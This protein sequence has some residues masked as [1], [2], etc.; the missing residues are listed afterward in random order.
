MESTPT[1]HIYTY[2]YIHVGLCRGIQ[3]TLDFLKSV[4]SNL[5]MVQ[6]DLDDCR[7][8]E[9]TACIDVQGYRI[10]I[11]RARQ[12]K[13]HD[14][15]DIAMTSRRLGVD[16]MVVG[17]PT[18]GPIH[19]IGQGVVILY[20]GSASPGIASDSIS[21][22]MLMDIK[23]NTMA[24]YQYTEQNAEDVRVERFEFSKSM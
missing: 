24:V 2:I 3:G 13:N 11:C 5:T 14:D 18:R 21:S 19:T 16:V 8:Y 17:C 9:H 12:N 4:S 6:G 20:P 23:G 15:D 22:F 7:T 10:G 1:R